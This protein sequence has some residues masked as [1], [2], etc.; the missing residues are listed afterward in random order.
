MNEFPDQDAR[1]PKKL[2]KAKAV[3]W[4]LLVAV[5][6]L[7]MPLMEFRQSGAISYESLIAALAVCVIVGIVLV[8]LCRHASNPEQ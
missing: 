6:A 7:L 8:M 3:A 1:P 5:G 2:T 4:F